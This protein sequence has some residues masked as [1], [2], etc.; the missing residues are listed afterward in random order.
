MMIASAMVSRLFD[1]VLEDDQCENNDKCDDAND[2]LIRAGSRAT[3]AVVPVRVI[4]A[5]AE[6]ISS[7]LRSV[8][9]S[10]AF[11]VDCLDVAGEE[12]SVNE[13]DK[14]A[15]YCQHFYRWSSLCCGVQFYL[16]KSPRNLTMI[17]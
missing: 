1:A 15:A 13:K 7:P 10:L 5:V 16:T 14:A 9:F 17:D 2:P 12:D 11:Q 3:V 4:V 8:H 6:V